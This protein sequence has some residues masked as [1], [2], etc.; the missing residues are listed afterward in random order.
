MISKGTLSY[1]GFVDSVAQEIWHNWTNWIPNDDG[2]EVDGGPVTFES[3]ATGYVRGS[4]HDAFEDDD[5]SWRS[6]ITSCGFGEEMEVAFL[7]PSCKEI[8][9]T[10]SCKFWLIDTIRSRYA[11]LQLIQAA[12]RDRAREQ[13]RAA[14]R[15]GEES[16]MRASPS[17]TSPRTISGSFPSVGLS[18][19]SSLSAIVQQN[20]P[21]KIVLYKGGTVTS[22]DGLLD[23]TGNVDE[24]NVPFTRRDCDLTSLTLGA[25]FAVD[26][27][28]AVRYARWTKRR[29]TQ[30]PACIIRIDVQNSALEALDASEKVS[31]YWPS[32]EWHTLVWTGRRGECLRG[33]LEKYKDATLVI[34]TT[35]GKPNI[36]ISQLSSPTA[37]TERMVLKNSRGGKAVQ[38]AFIG[39]RGRDFLERHC[40]TA[41]TMHP[42]T[43]RDAEVFE[44]SLATSSA[45][46]D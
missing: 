28:V 26:Y 19:I 39:E 33:D 44:A 11:C 13:A 6:S 4:G 18:E 29:D 27:D 15:P 38:Y 42:F 35:Y 22:F 46:G 23:H 45:G 20:A 40:Q 12:S 16:M 30:Q 5:E 34:G 10:E 43:T 24:M 36:V 37:I 32:G 9:L 14:S 8:R 1:L 21:G 17:T 7:D 41:C 2:R 31:I 25:Y 3:M